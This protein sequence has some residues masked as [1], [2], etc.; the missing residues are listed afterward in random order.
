MSNLV[1]MGSS[2]HSLLSNDVS[3]QVPISHHLRLSV[4]TAIFNQVI[5]IM[6]ANEIVQHNKG[7]DKL[8]L[9][10]D[11][12]FRSADQNLVSLL[13]DAKYALNDIAKL[14]MSQV[15]Q[16]LSILRPHVSLA[17]FLEVVPDTMIG[18]Q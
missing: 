5:G 3:L 17:P 7:Q 15:K 11:F 8:S 14:G 13:E 2:P 6:N 9:S 18:H 10:F 4:L 12:V 16:F 1:S